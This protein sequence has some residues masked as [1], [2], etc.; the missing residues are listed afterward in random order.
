[1]TKKLSAVDR[2]RVSNALTKC[3]AA[4]KDIETNEEL[5][6]KAYQKAAET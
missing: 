1:M 6:D 3:A 5:A 4:T 2:Q